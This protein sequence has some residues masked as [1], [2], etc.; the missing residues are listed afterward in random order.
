MS[1]TR[2]EHDEEHDVLIL[3]AGLSGVYSL[4]CLRNYFSSRRVKVLEAGTD[5]RGTWG[6]TGT[7]YRTRF[8]VSCPGFLSS[9]TLPNIPGIN[10]VAGQALHTSR[11]PAEFDVSHDFAGKRIGVVST[12]ATGTQT[13]TAISKEPSIKSSSNVTYEQ[14]FKQCAETLTGFLHAADPRQSLDVTEEERQ[15]LW[16]KLYNE[17]G[18]GKW[19]GVLSDTYTDRRANKLCSNSIANKIRPRVHDPIT[20]ESLTPR[21]HGFGTRRVPLESKY[22]EALKK[23]HV[24]LFDLQQATLDEVTPTGIGTNVGILPDLD[25]LIFATGFDAITGAF[26]AISWRGKDGRPLIST[27][28]EEHESATWPGQRPRT[29]LGLTVPAMPNMF[30]VLGPHQPF[31]NGTRSIEHAVKVISDLLVFCKEHSVTYIEP[32]EEA[33][34]RWTEYVIECSE[35]LVLVREV[36]SWMIGINRNVKGKS[37]KSVVRYSRSAIE[38]RKWCREGGEGGWKDFV[39]IKEGEGADRSGKA[40]GV[41]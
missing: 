3:G 20:A 39:L 7:S 31:G 19:L 33:V 18:F 4:Y 40:E 34:E 9:L 5:V 1:V 22:F 24:H 2:L 36:D 26:S 29:F 27:C 28:Q 30:M 32:R 25:I 17:P 41:V 15:A 14:L 37:M 23:P 8:F 35:A 12:G 10:V 6:E 13:I 38:Y 16:E 21:S 11:W